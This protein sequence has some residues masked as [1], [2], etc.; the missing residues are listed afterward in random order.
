MM[1]VGF[2]RVWVDFEDFFKGLGWFRRV[3]DGLGWFLE[4]LDGF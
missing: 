1:L 3:L 2:W 4:S